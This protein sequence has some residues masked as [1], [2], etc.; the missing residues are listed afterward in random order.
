VGLG[1]TTRAALAEGIG[2]QSIRT[3]SAHS[4]MSARIVLNRSRLSRSDGF[5]GSGPLGIR[6]RFWILRAIAPCRQSGFCVAR[7]VEM[8]RL[9]STPKIRC[10][11]GLRRSASTITVLSPA[12]AITTPRFAVIVL[13]PSPGLGLLIAND[14]SRSG[15][16]AKI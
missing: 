16:D 11:V 10:W 2:V 1:A 9:L 7:S 3:T 4:P 15:A 13:L 14:D 5:G 12:F 6:T 8:P